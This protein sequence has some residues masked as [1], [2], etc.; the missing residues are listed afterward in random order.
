VAITCRVS[1]PAP[2]FGGCSPPGPAMPSRV[3]VMG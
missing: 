1:T 2:P 3:A